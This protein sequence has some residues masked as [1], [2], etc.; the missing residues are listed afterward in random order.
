MTFCPSNQR[1]FQ[2]DYV[3]R[4]CFRT[5]AVFLVSDVYVLVR[6]CPDRTVMVSWAL[7]TSYRFL[8]LS[9]SLPLC[10]YLSLSL[11]LS[12]SVSL[13]LCLS[14]S[15]CLSLCLYLS[16]SVSVCLSLSLSLSVSLYRH[17]LFLPVFLCAF[18]PSDGR[19][20]QFGS[21]FTVISTL[22]ACAPS[23]LVISFPNVECLKQIQCGSG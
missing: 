9:L 3:F 22:S 4:S 2:P 7:T 6:F 1:S 11:C 23:S 10:L 21:I 13:C 15:L 17:P 5:L 20:V 12:L 14:L 8:S 16:L 19:L 18:L